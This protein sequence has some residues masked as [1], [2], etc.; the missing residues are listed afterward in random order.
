MGQ[1]RLTIEVK[2]FVDKLAETDA[3]PLYELS[4]EQARQVLLEA[5][6]KPIAK[7]EVDVED[8]NIPLGDE[9][10]SMPVRI[11]RPQNAQGKIPVIFYIHGGGWVMGNEK[12]HDRLIRRICAETPAAVVFPI[13]PNAPEGQ[14]PQ[15]IKDLFAV[16]ENVVANADKLNFDTSRLAV[17]GDSVGANMATVTALMAKELGDRPKIIFQLLFYPVTSADFNTDSYQEFA[18][19]PWLTRRAM[20][21]FWDSYCP[22][23]SQ[24]SEITASPLNA[25][26]KQLGGLPPALVITGE[27]DVLRDEGEAYAHKLMSAGVETVAI[28]FNG[29]I[30]DFVML[31]ALADSK[32]S[33]AAVNFAIMALRKKFKLNQ[34]N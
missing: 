6:S 31:D 7:A 3:K 20:Q 11:L 1:P 4:P 17:A 9:E 5:Q 33:R 21:W 29:T 27:N 23:V 10:K 19:G 2:R 12:T 18:E 26:E 14:Y 28:R 15:V 25:D 32:T 16:L 24:R 30:H 13:Y 34:E 8:L 22:D